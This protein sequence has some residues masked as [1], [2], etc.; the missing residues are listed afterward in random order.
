MVFGW[1]LGGFWVVF[2]WFLS[3]F[4][5]VFGCFLGGFCEVYLDVHTLEFLVIVFQW[6]LIMEVLYLW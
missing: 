1:L 4:W 3:G 6:R 5:V 2:K